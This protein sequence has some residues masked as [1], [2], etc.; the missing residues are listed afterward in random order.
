M[1]T[2]LWCEFI[3]GLLKIFLGA[4]NSIITN[5]KKKIKYKHQKYS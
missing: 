5:I 1:A 3:S 4:S 2:Y